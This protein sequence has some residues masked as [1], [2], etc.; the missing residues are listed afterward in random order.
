VIQISRECAICRSFFLVIIALLCPH[1]NA[2]STINYIQNNFLSNIMLA[3]NKSKNNNNNTKI[4][5]S[6]HDTVSFF[7][8]REMHG[9]PQ[10]SPLN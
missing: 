10:H 9:W 6:Y 7:I 8:S 3:H 2:G 1:K 4:M 5:I